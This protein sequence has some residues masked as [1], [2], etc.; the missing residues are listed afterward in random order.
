[1]QEFC[2]H[3]NAT[4]TDRDPCCVDLA[5]RSMTT[6]EFIVAHATLFASGALFIDG[7]E[8]VGRAAD[9]T[10]VHIAEYHDMCMDSAHRYLLDH[11]TPDTW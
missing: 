4:V 6:K 3:C 1:M 2:P 7:R 9:G 10:E 8:I 11:P 5:P